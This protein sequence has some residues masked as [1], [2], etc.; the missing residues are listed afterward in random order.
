MKKILLMMLCL[1]SY[2]SGFA[3][4]AVETTVYYAVSASDVNNGNYT[5]KLN[6]NYKGDG[7]EWDATKVMTKTNKT[8]FGKYI[9]TCT[10]SS[11]YGGLGCLA[12]TIYDGETQKYY[13]KKFGD[14][15]WKDASFYNGKMG[16]YGQ[17]DLRTYNYDKT[18]TIHCK[19]NGGWTP[20]NCHNYFN[21][22][23]TGDVKE[24][25]FPGYVTTQS[26]LNGDWYDYTISGR[27]CTSAIMSNG[28]SGEG[29]QSGTI[30][31]GDAKE[32]WVTYDG[33]NTT[34]D[35]NAPASFSY[36]RS[37]TSGKYGTICLPYAA[38]IEGATIYEI[39]S[40]VIEGG[41]LK[42]I[43]VE[44]IATNRVEAGVA[45]IFKGTSGTLTAT[46]SGNYTDAA[47]DGNMMGNLDSETMTVPA[48][49]DNY[50]VSNNQIRKVVSG[51]DGVT[52][53]R[54]RAYIKLGSVSAGARGANFIGSDDEGTTGIE[55]VNAENNQS[56]VY[57]LQGQRVNDTQ[58]GLVI[59][60]GK[61]LLRK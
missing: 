43:N 46:L 47:T 34:C 31:I 52:I 20:T 55:T 41:V 8:Y 29:Y 17:S 15:E 30:S 32:Y 27:P 45:Y 9:Y 49:Q 54:Y 56:V 53:A 39:E 40:Q 58:K 25:D 3:G 4:D 10:F 12:F 44:P 5:V 6:L 57:N 37:V 11:K 36:T 18:V 26:T 7:D 14:K 38:T 1:A 61:K 59:V 42:G 33:T 23:V 22:G 28:S 2:V 21:D 35:S 51:S 19:K 48:D 16:E 60:N 13:D 50:V 24:T